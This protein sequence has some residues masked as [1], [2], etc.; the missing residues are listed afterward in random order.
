MVATSGGEL[1]VPNATSY[2][3]APDDAYRS[4]LE[5]ARY[6]LRVREPDHRMFRTPERDVH[7]HVWAEGS[8]EARRIVA[9]R[10]RL[11]SDEGDRAEYERVKR[12]LIGRFRDLNA[13]AQ[14]KGPVI[15]RILGHA[16]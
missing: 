2:E 7:V 15:E 6:V 10:D 3:V 11:R 14:A 4:R 5:A 12:G 9:F 16:V 1:L 8:D 13:Y